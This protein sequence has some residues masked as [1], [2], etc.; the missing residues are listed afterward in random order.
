MRV[1]VDTNVLVSGLLSPFNAP[2]RVVDLILEKSVDVVMDDRIIADYRTVLLRPKFGFIDYN[3]KALISYLRQ[4]GQFVTALPIAGLD[5][6]AVP[7]IDD[8]PFAEVAVAGGVE[9]LITGNGAHFAF[10][11]NVRWPGRVVTPAEFMA[12]F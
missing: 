6:A 9:R 7:D 10:M 2:G 12:E 4:V 5:R 11:A 1:V 3:V 8:L